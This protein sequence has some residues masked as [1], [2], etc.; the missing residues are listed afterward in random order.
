MDVRR[1]MAGALPST[2]WQQLEVATQGGP[3]A[4]QLPSRPRAAATLCSYGPRTDV[5]IPRAAHTPPLFIAEVPRHTWVVHPP[6]RSE[7]GGSARSARGETPDGVLVRMNV[8]C[9]SPFS[10]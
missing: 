3:H 6:E 8:G 4:A 7:Q 10:L 2:Q 1:A 9:E 5:H